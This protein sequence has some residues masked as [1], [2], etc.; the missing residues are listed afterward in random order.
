MY[1]QGRLVTKLPP[2]VRPTDMARAYAELELALSY[3]D[4]EQMKPIDKDFLAIIKYF[5]SRLNPCDRCTYHHVA[6]DNKRYEHFS[7]FSAVLVNA[8]D[9]A[10]CYFMD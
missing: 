2:N 7:S 5:Q 6:G 1:Y 4:Y 9:E 3:V 10:V 8:V